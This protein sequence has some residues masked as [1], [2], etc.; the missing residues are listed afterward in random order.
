M[1]YDLNYGS[2][3]SIEYHPHE[4]MLALSFWEEG[5]PVHIYAAHDRV[6]MITPLMYLY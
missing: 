5:V 6:G 3:S 1:L 2:I 4:H